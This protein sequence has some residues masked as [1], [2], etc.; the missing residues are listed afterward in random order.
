MW[1][2]ELRKKDAG[3][4]IVALPRSSDSFWF[5]STA[6]IHRP[7]DCLARRLFFPGYLRLFRFEFLLVS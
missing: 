3:H 5:W 4:G 1:Y 6:H 2:I 7:A